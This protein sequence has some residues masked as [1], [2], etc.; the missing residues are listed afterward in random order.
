MIVTIGWITTVIALVTVGRRTILTFDAGAT[1]PSWLPQRGGAR[2]FVAGVLI[3]LLLL[4][5][6][7]ALPARRRAAIRE[8]MENAFLRL[9][10]ILPRTGV[11]RG[12]W[13][14]VSLTSV[15][16]HEV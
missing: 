15:I 2:T 7:S 6:L 3:G 9:T 11:E 5:A 14:F 16:C 10:F 12:W 13:L 1:S 4:I 8:K